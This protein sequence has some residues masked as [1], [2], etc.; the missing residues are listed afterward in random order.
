MRF[1]EGQ[2][3]KCRVFVTNLN[4]CSVADVVAF[5]NKQA[6]VESRIKESNNDAGQRRIRQGFLR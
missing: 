5:Y 2:A 6:A 3:C 4:G 1:F